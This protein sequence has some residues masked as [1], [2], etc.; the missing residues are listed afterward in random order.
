MKFIFLILFSFLIFIPVSGYGLSDN[1]EIDG[2]SQVEIPSEELYRIITSP[3]DVSRDVIVKIHGPMGSSDGKI[4]ILADYSLTINAG[5]S[6]TQFFHKFTSPIYHPDTDYTIE[7]MGDGLVGRKSV[8]TI[9]QPI[10][11]ILI[12]EISFTTNSDTLESG[13]NFSVSG[14]VNNHDKSNPYVEINIIRPDGESIT[15]SNT[16]LNSFGN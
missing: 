1:V 7:V 11:K 4:I 15:L 14:K 12:P 13:D 10:T 5:S 9:D 8:K 3:S 2:S 6:Y 16:P